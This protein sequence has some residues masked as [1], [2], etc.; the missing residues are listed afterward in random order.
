MTEGDP[1][2]PPILL[3]SRYALVNRLAEARHSRLVPQHEVE[4]AAD[5]RPRSM[6]GTAPSPRPVG[7]QSP[8]TGTQR[9][10]R[11]STEVRTGLPRRRSGASTHDR[12]R[13]TVRR[14]CAWIEAFAE[15]AAGD[16]ASDDLAELLRRESS[17][18]SARVLRKVSSISQR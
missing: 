16:P 18:R 17:E 9:G 3:R 11:Q 10:A 8:S 13:H 4:L 2:G 14:G 7:G 5:P 12:A 1:R 6:G 15:F